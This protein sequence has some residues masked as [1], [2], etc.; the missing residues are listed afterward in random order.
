MLN[1][2]NGETSQMVIESYQ[3]ILYVIMCSHT[4][5][6]ILFLKGGAGAMAV[7]ASNFYFV[8]PRCMVRI[9]WTQEFKRNLG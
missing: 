3:Y 8:L 7:E 5:L 9:F 2:M 1:F 6:Y 4:G